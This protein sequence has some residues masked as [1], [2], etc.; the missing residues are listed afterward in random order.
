MFALAFINVSAL[1]LKVY[2]LRVRPLRLTGRIV[3]NRTGAQATLVDAARTDKA[4]M[5]FHLG[6]FAPTFA[7]Y[8]RA[9]VGFAC[10]THGPFGLESVLI[11]G[12]C[13]VGTTPVT[14]W[15]NAEEMHCFETVVSLLDAH[16]VAER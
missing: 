16:S 5:R 9:V 4:W 10:W 2:A 11:S 1:Y 15:R 6:N 7:N 3:T 12:C 14:V 8:L 13:R